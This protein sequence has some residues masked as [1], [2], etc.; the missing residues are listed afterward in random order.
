MSHQI[1][2]KEPGPPDDEQPERLTIGGRIRRALIGRP[3]DVRDRSL[4]HKLSLIPFLA[5][6]G[7]GSDGLSS[8]AYGPEE[9]FRALGEH[10]SLAVVLAGLVAFTVII[11]SLAYSRIIERFPSGGGG[12]IVATRTL[13]KRAG[14]VS[15]SALLVDYV[16]TITISIAAAGDAIWSFLPASWATAK[17]PFEASIIVLMTILNL[18]GVR[19]SVVP[20][21]PIFIAFLIT[22]LILIGGGIAT[23]LGNVSATAATVA[24][25]FRTGLDTLGLGGMLL[26]V[27]HAYSLGGGTFTGIE[28]VSNGVAIMREPK[29]ETAKRTMLYMAV[30]LAVTAAGLLLCYLLWDIRPVDGKTMNAVLAERFVGATDTGHP[31]VIATLAAEGA[32]LILAAQAGFLDGPRVLST[33]AID[34]W[35]PRR[36]ATLSDRLTTQNGILLMGTTSLAA[37]LLTGGNV[38]ALVVMYSINVFITFSLS[39]FGMLLD[40]WQRRDEPKRWRGLV[41]FTVGFG[42]CATI[43]CVTVV[44]KFAE[45]GWITILV[46]GFLIALCF[47]IRAHYARI[48]KRFETLD[49]E[50]ASVA[51]TKASGEAEPIATHGA[52]PPALD[53]KSGTAAVLVTRFGGLGVRTVERIFSDFPNH[54]KNVVFISVSVVDS[55]AFRDESALAES[56]RRAERAL[57]QY[58]HWAHDRGGVAATK[59]LGVGIDVIDELEKT[60]RAVAEE[61]PNVVFFAGRIAFAHEQWYHAILHND[62][63]VALQKRLQAHGHTL[64]VLPATVL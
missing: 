29:V 47:L 60:C 4:F 3:R 30:S 16:F 49:M 11:I 43:L 63:T 54:F 31:F 37:L 12:Y 34:Y 22:H 46:T 7:L 36:F 48:A 53:P 58:V 6:V 9:A 19:E 55:S 24:K 8:S 50:T 57:D 32:I 2:D 13:G 61:Y 15:G 56:T 23:H 28:A 40:R 38:R 62:S 52:V 20:L 1:S 21:A 64:V 35:V 17:I 41:L 10:R 26:I 18:R 42:L 59:R 45:G 39:M 27:L 5:W 14:V 25:D 44:E 51:K 33:M